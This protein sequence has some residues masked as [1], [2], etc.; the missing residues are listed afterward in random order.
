MK[1][2]PSKLS[3]KTKNAL[4]AQIFLAPFYLGFVF[5]FLY[6]AIESVRMSFSA[7][8]VN[9]NGYQLENI[10]WEN[11]KTAFLTDA[12]FSTNL[13]NTLTKM[14]WRVPSIVLLGLFSAMIINQKFRG[15]A[16]VRAIFFMPVIFSAGFAFQLLE[17]DAIVGS[18]LS[19]STISGGE[20]TKN[21]FFS[22][23]L[24][25]FGM[26]SQVISVVSMIMNNLFA[27]LWRMGIQ[28]II[29][30]AGLQSIPTSLY[31]ASSIE[32]ASAWENFWKITLPMLSPMIILNLIYTIVDDCTV[33]NNPIM[34][35]I[36][37]LM[38]QEISKMGLSSAFAWVYFLVIGTVLLIILLIYKRFTSDSQVRRED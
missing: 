21:E 10:G 33:S 3:M 18:M 23:F 13:V 38:N 31:E 11:Y 19:G 14:L 36:L 30:L 22:G 17:G 24:V 4:T 15:R 20:I 37:S 2:S 27:L 8:S 34:R 9:M 16:F 6:P 26:G 12:T 5:F 28:M 7:V 1:K 32:G 25:K 35:Q 29:F